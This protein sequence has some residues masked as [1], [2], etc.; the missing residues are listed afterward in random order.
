MSAKAIAGC[1][2]ARIA[3]AETS[4]LK[5]DHGFTSLFDGKTLNGWTSKARLANQPSLGVWRVEDS[6]IVGGQDR[7]GVGSYLVSDRTFSDFELEIEA[8]P[9]WPADTGIYVRANE[10]GATGFQVNLDYRPH[11]SIGGY[12]G[13]GFGSFHAY[14]YGFTA[15]RD[16]SGHVTRL[17]PGKPQQPNDA[18]HLVKP[19]YMVSAED[20]LK[21]W[22][23]NDWNR[24]RIRSV[25]AVPTLTTWV[26]DLK[27]SEL[28]T[29][30]MVASDWNPNK[31]VDMVGRAGHISLEV[32]NNAP[33]D[34][35]GND[36][37]APG[38]L[39]RWRSIRVREL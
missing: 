19:D 29:S 22:K 28:V 35:L 37:W 13:N 34:W 1:M 16:A 8:R 32:H 23:L 26:N 7:A 27:V 6:A 3:G 11:G 12:F 14:E 39:C 10:Q 36:R 20:L 24:F 15:E 9:D 2:V 17:I 38:A 5:S 33:G 25:G 30:K 21:V 18:G 4:A 31:V